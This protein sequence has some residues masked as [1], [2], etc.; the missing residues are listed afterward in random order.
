MRPKKLDELMLNLETQPSEDLDRRIAGMITQ[1][2]KQG[3]GGVSPELALWRRIMQSKTT[4]LAALIAIVL[5]SIMALHFFESTTSVTWAGVIDPLMT[6]ETAVFNVVT[7]FQGATIEAKIMVM[8]QRIRSEFEPSQGLP[9]TIFDAEHLQMLTLLPGK[10]QAILIDLR[11]LADE[12]PENYLESIRDVIRELENDPNASID[13]LPDS[14]IDGRNAVVFR[15]KNDNDEMT[16]W[17]DPE[18]L[19]PIRL[20]QSQD[21]LSVVCTDFRF[22]VDLDSSLFSMDIPAGYS[23]ASGQL[24]FDDS[25]EKKV[26]EGL[27]IWAQ[28]L[29]D[30]QFPEDLTTATYQKMPG[31]RK[32]LQNGTL[33]LSMQEKV[34]MG[35]KIAPLSRFLMSLKPEQDWHYVGAGV[36][37]G[38]ANQPVCWYKPI[39]S[40]TYR[41]VFGDL[42]VEN[43]PRENL[44]K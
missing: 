36:P 35:M 29:E 7:H 9:T 1:A 24:D 10:K 12:A 19:L 31:L 2:A 41:V 22:D 23:T 25:A 30:N 38:D 43:M 34:D 42:S 14:E 4:Q 18:T 28:I 32:K 33:K 21:G 17:A 27:R 20:E 13:R 6:A 16:V 15:A 40:E 26:L 8:G 3:S 44:P 5:V 39:G 11:D 37:F